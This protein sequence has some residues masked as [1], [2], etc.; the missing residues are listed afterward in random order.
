MRNVR[1]FG[2]YNKTNV[3]GD[4]VVG[5]L[6]AALHDE[7]AKAERHQAIIVKGRD[8]LH[9]GVAARIAFE[10]VTLQPQYDRQIAVRRIA[11]F[12]RAGAMFMDPSGIGST[13]RA[14]GAV[15]EGLD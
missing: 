13:F 4:A 5:V 3:V 2:G 10:A 14:I 15:Q 1:A 12:L 9:P 8:L 11:E 7:L 6:E